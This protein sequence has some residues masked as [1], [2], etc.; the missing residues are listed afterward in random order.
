MS[1]TSLKVRCALQTDY[2]DSY[3]FHSG[4]NEMFKTPGLWE[5]LQQQVK[6]GKIRHF[7][8]LCQPQ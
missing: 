6:A 4:N 2:I 1:S 5:L 8:N 3:Q 7:G